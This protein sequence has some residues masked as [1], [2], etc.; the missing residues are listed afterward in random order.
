MKLRI[1]K[2]GINGEGIGYID[3][4]PVFVAGALVG[5]TVEVSISVKQKNYMHARLVKIIDSSPVRID[6]PCRFQ[7]YCSGCALMTAPVWQQLKWKRS[8][9][10][11]TLN[12][13]AGIS[14]RMVGSIVENPQPFSYRNQCKIPLLFKNGKLVGGLYRENSNQIVPFSHC[15]IHDPNLERCRKAVLNILNQADL[16]DFADG[17]GIRTLVM[18]IMNNQIQITLISGR[19][20]IPQF[21]IEAILGLDNVVSLY[22]N[23]QLNSKSHELF[24]RE[25]IHLGGS[26]VLTFEL[27]GLHLQLSPN[28]FFQLNTAQALQMFQKIASLV[29]PCDTLVEAYCGVGTIS[30][31]LHEKAKEIIGIEIVEAAIE[32]AKANA[33]ANGIENCTFLCGDSAKECRRIA[34][35]KK[36]DCLVVDPPRSGLDDSML[37]MMADTKIAQIIYVS[38][39]PSTLAKNL[40]VLLKSYKVEKILPYDMF[41]HTP[42]IETIAVLKRL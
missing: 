8:L 30:L 4:K 15:I 40:A 39:N 35:H 25:M 34:K 33:A 38:C 27:N 14:S 19:T 22:Q 7:K 26:K 21:C 1:M 32:N 2:M 24:G 36:I 16:R 12:K 10:Q 29:E 28:S 9:L 23:I 17:K 6:P 37:S 42:L 5:E 13:Y 3:Q 31:M 20:V 41:T 11:Q 18:R